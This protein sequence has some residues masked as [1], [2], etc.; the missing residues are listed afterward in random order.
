MGVIVFQDQVLLI[1]QKFAGYTLGEADSVRRAMGKKIPAV[2]AQEREKFIAGALAQGYE[3]ELAE[4]VFF[5]H[6]A[7]RGVRIQQGAQC[8]LRL[9][10][11]L[12]GVLQGQLSARVHGVSAER[13][14][15]ELG[16]GSRPSSAS[17]SV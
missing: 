10:L 7:L 9:D 2:M 8:V 14:L 3:Q 4:R 12:D 13:V 16:E 5:P 6:R 11:L 17:A 1:T 15:G